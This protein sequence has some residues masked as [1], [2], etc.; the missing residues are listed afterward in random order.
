[1]AKAAVP[2]VRKPKEAKH[3]TEVDMEIA[4]AEAKHRADRTVMSIARLAGDNMSNAEAVEAASAWR[5]SPES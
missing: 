1:M 4:R 2:K 3:I 5:V